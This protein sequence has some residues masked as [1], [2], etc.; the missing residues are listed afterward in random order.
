MNNADAINRW[1]E[2]SV[3]RPEKT[4]DGERAF[5]L[6]GLIAEKD[7]KIRERERLAAQNH[8]DIDARDAA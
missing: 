1:L 6:V 8:T 2:P 4:P 5:E 7:G 3:Q